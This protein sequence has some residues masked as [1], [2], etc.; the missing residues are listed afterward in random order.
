[1]KPF[2]LDTVLSYRERLE[3]LAQEALAAARQAEDEV[4]DK[5]TRKRHIYESLVA[6]ISTIQEQGVSI[7]DLISQE[8]HLAYIKNEIKNLEQHLVE[9]REQVKKSH[10]QLVEKSKQRQVMEKLKE[11][12]NQAWKE[13]LNKKEAAM[14]DEMAIVFH[15]RK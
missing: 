14:L 1:M 5:L 13:Y 9:K 15:D 7:N 2:T 12:Q 11:R 4:Q 6:H 10:A 3:T 8:E